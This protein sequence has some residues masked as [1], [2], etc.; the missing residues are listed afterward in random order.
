[1]VATRLDCARRLGSLLGAAD[2][3]LAFT[4]AGIGPTIG[5]GLQPLSAPGLTRLLLH[6][7]RQADPAEPRP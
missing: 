2:G 7:E 1:M 6:R 5:N 4:L 3:G